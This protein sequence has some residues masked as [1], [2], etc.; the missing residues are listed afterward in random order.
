MVLQIASLL[1]LVHACSCISDKII[2][3]HVFWN[4]FFNPSKNKQIKRI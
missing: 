3:F 1:M 2:P 4:F